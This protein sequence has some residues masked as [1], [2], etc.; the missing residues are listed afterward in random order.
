[1]FVLYVLRVCYKTLK[2]NKFTRNTFV[3]AT[4]L[5]SGGVK[6]KIYL[7]GAWWRKG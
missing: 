4:Y 3:I 2:L 5:K 6:Q 1:V 7:R